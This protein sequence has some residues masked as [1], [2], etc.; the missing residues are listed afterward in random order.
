MI[1][2]LNKF[3][4]I[5]LYLLPY[6]QLLYN[7]NWKLMELVYVRMKY[8]NLTRQYEVITAVFHLWWDTLVMTESGEWIII[9]YLLPYKQL[10]YNQ[11]WKLMELVYVRMKYNNLTRQ[12]EVITAVFHLWW[13]TLVMTESGEWIIIFFLR[14]L[15][16]Y[17]SIFL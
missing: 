6:K 11:N 9:L 7:Q 5:L 4:N 17:F 13:D 3:E 1:S 16:P 14:Y 2:A 10:L 15:F 12:Y 8:N